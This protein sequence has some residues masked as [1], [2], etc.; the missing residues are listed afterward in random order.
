MLSSFSLRSAS[1]I[2][3][4]GPSSGCVTV[5][6][7]LAP[8]LVSAKLTMVSEMVL[9][10]GAGWKILGESGSEIAGDAEEMFI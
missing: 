1:L 8:G 9:E 6:I 4:P 5:A 7:F 3:E 10:V 2:F